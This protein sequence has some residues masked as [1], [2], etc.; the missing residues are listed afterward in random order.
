MLPGMTESS[1][2]LSNFPDSDNQHR[3]RRSSIAV[4]GHIA[5]VWLQIDRQADRLVPLFGPGAGQYLFDREEVCAQIDRITSLHDMRAFHL[6]QLIQSPCAGQVEFHSEC[7]IWDDAGYF[8]RNRGTRICYKQITRISG[9]QIWLD[10]KRHEAKH[11]Q[12]PKVL[13]L[14]AYFFYPGRSEEHY[15]L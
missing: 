4:L 9:G 6:R 13:Q 12:I 10:E 1:Q 15:S 11:E 7:L 3:S 2:H 8:A 5:D 14:Q